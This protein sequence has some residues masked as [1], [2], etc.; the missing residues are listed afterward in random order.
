MASSLLI[1]SKTVPSKAPAQGSDSLAF[2]PGVFACPI[3]FRTVFDL[4]QRAATNPAQVAR[5]LEATVLHNFAV[6]NRP[7]LSVYKDES[8]DIFY[9]K[10]Q[11]KG[12]GIDAEGQV[13]LLVYGLG[14]PGPS[15]TNQ[16]RILLQRRLLLIAVDMLSNVLTKNPHFKWKRAD[17]VFLR[18]F[19][20]EWME[21]E[22][23][24]KKRP[25]QYRYYK[26]PEIVH[27]PC[28]VLLYLRQNLCGSTFFHRLNDMDQTGHNPS[29]SITKKDGDGVLGDGV[30]LKMNQHEFS[31]YYNYAPSKLEPSFQGLSTMTEK[32]AEYCRQTGTGIAMIEFT[33]V[34]TNGDYVDEISFA[35]HAADSNKVEGLPSELLVEG[36]SSY[37]IEDNDGAVCARV[38]ITDTALNRDA[39]HDWIRL[40]LNQATVAWIT[41]RWLEKSFV[42][43]PSN[44]RG[45]AGPVS[46]MRKSDSII[47]R[48]CPSLPAVS[49]ILDSSYD[50]PHSAIRKFEGSGVTRASSVATLTLNLLHR[51]ILSPLLEK[52]LLS[53][54]GNSRQRLTLDRLSK[55][56]RIVRLSRFANPKVVYMNWA[57]RGIASVKSYSSDGKLLEIIDSPVDCPEYLCFFSVSERDNDLL[58][59]DSQLRLYREVVVHDGISEKSASIDLL[60]AIKTTRPKAFL[61][62]FSFILSVKRNSRTLWTYNWNPDIAKR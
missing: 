38:K 19:E 42:W 41:E 39:L 2:D 54:S 22:N 10:I 52:K 6:S 35:Q 49:S 48:L 12:S 4:Y 62:S 36:L 29:P 18:S 58:S 45:L 32:G 17:F 26:F 1:P 5:T 20:K 33:L 27:D 53:T 11:P 25:S 55:H 59:I 37:P 40:T 16:L 13:E 46:R 61:R 30:G 28:M 34:R 8:G 51:E 9:M 15:V 47:D 24:E 44:H 43:F 7:G 14:D 60:E 3:V 21:L 50:L 56:V 57:K 31:L 23:S